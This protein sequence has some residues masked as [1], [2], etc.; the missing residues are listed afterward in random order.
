MKGRERVP[1]SSICT[2]CWLGSGMPC[3]EIPR[4]SPGRSNAA[5]ATSGRRGLVAAGPLEPVDSQPV[6]R[7]VLVSAIRT[8]Q[9][10]SVRDVMSSV[11]RLPAGTKAKSATLLRGRA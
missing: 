4:L 3:S 10:R 11:Q 9:M 1:S 7:I 8:V 2:S 6:Q 5:D